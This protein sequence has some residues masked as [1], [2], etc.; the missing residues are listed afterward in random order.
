MKGYQLLI[1]DVPT[2]ELRHEAVVIEVERTISGMGAT[3]VL[4]RLAPSRSPPKVMC[5]DNGMESMR[6]WSGVSQRTT[7]K[8]NPKKKGRGIPRPSFA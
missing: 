6:E 8:V 3:L 4:D 5:T 7:P 2:T 1:C